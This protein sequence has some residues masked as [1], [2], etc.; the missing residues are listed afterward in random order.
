[1]QFFQRLPIHILTQ[2]MT[3]TNPL[4]RGPITVDKLE[5]IELSLKQLNLGIIGLGNQGKLHLQNCLLRKELNVAAVADTSKH[6]LEYATNRGVKRTYA[7]YEDLLRDKNVDAVIINLPNYLH[8]ES[9][10][11][12]AEAGKDILL[13]KPLAGRLE[14][15]EKIVSSVEKNG[16]KL[17][18]GYTLRFDPL[19]LNLR[20][21]IVNGY[22]GEVEIAQASNI[23][24][25]PFT[26]Q[27]DR[28]GPVPV[29]NWWFDKELVGGGALLDL[30]IHMVDLLAWYFG[31]VE[32]VSSYLGYT[33]NMSVEDTATCVMKF[34][35]GPLALVNAG[36]FSRDRLMSIGLNGTSRNFSEVLNKKSRLRF[37]WNDFKS[38]LGRGT[39]STTAEE[40][41]YFVDC[42]SRDVEPSPSAK[43]GLLDLRI[44]SMAY[45]HASILTKE[46]I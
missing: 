41:K 2:K 35:N 46:K 36:W 26:E 6:A 18:L 32:S 7:N 10:T 8:L 16:V 21:R 45:K 22:F 38:I 25:G 29:P 23:S 42:I 33:L 15:G 12:A 27:A 1:M 4:S 43:E 30:G 31:E 19:F 44:I 24:T 39:A 17:M 11:K 3:K 13:E 9:A 14:E 37:I 40:L 5:R 28:L 34:K 20:E